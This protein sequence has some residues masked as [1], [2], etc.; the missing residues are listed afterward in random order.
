MTVEPLDVDVMELAVELGDPS[1]EDAP[2]SEQIVS[3][4]TSFSAMGTRERKK[5]KL[6]WHI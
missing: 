3:S 2:S 4:K 5:I 1:D 6:Q